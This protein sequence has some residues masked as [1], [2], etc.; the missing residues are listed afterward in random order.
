MPA[1]ATFVG[2]GFGAIQSGLF[3][4][5]AFNSGGFNRLV[6]A[7]V[8]PERVD[9]IRRSGGS[10]SVN[11][12]AADKRIVQTVTGVEIYNPMVPEDAELLIDALAS[13]SEISTALPSVLFYD[14][15]TP[16]VA[17]LLR[18][19]CGRKIA[20]PTLPSAIIY[21]AENN[22]HAA[23]RLWEDI[24]RPFDAA[25]SAAAAGRMQALN[26]VVGK[27]SSVVT[28]PDQIAA[29]GLAP[30]VPGASEAF[31]V[32][33]FNRILI[34]KIALPDCERRI[35]VFEEKMD[36]LPFEE[37]KLYGHNAIHALLGYLAHERGLTLMSEIAD[38]PD[39]L[40]IGRSAFL[41]ESGAA[42]VRKYDEL[43]PLFTLAGMNAYAEELL[44]R[45]LNPNLQDPVD[46]IVRDPL[47]KLGWNDRLIG[48][49]R[50]ALEHDIAPTNLLKGA[51]AA[52]QTVAGPTPMK[53]LLAEWE[54]EGASRDAIHRVATLL[55]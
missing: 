11:S 29:L 43:D 20:D 46:R 49:I 32:E 13:A 34:S 54:T 12:A 47:R 7:E 52:L 48:T 39:L 17:G 28:D 45:M 44:V 50:L 10:F 31:L 24:G 16:S 3:L 40:A 4:T 37:A 6:V 8:L 51:R 55:S 22:N 26:T 41:D 15:G 1:G 42:L 19:A 30:I 2:F 27:M 21:T 14:R 5:E 23:E 53:A 33:A 36:L 35:S 9:A 38:H 25:G 18:E